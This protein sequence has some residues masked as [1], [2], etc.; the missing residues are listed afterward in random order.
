MEGISLKECLLGLRKRKWLI[1]II[2]I[3]SILIVGIGTS[4]TTIPKYKSSTTLIISGSEN[5]EKLE[6]DPKYLNQKLMNT[7]SEIIKSKSVMDEVEKNLNLNFKEINGNIDINII[8]NTDIIKIEVTGKKPELVAD[9]TNEIALVSM[10]HAK[11]MIDIGNARV[12]DKAKPSRQPI[13]SSTR[14]NIAIAGIFGFAGSILVVFLIEYF[15]TTIKT[16]RDVER[17]LG[18]PVSGI[19]PKTQNDLSF[20]KE[21]NS[22]AAESYRTLRTNVKRFKDVQ[23]VKSILITSSNINKGNGIIASNIALAM[24]QIEE[25]VLLIDGNM[26]EPEVGTVFK[27]G[28]SFGLSDILSGDISYNEAINEVEMEKNLKIL[29]SGT[30]NIN[31]AELLAS[32]DMQNLLEKVRDEYD[33]I[34]INS[35]SLGVISDATVISTMVDGTYL[36]CESGQSHIEEVRMGKKLLDKV[37]ANILGVVL[38]MV[39]VEESRF[40]KYSYDSY[41]HYKANNI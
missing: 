15:D 4:L 21:P 40:C 30:K 13:K 27:L 10:N 7:Y 22:F 29:T 14:A 23:G 28:N 34:I 20:Y 8:P 33:T 25:S 39:A 2:T 31:P 11:E 6:S 17:Y 18:L 32:K 35:P 41:M 36:V 24:A 16:E 37:N 12:V 5:Q 9:V 38:N 19:I 3:V 26:R 1:I